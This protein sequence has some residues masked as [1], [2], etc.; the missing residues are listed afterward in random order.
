[1]LDAAERKRRSTA[2]QQQINRSRIAAERCFVCDRERG[3]TGTRTMC[4]VCADRMHALA[5]R[6]IAERSAHGL[7]IQCGRNNHSRTQHC[8]KCRDRR[9]ARERERAGLPSLAP[10]S[11]APHEQRVITHKLSE[12]QREYLRIKRRE[13]RARRRTQSEGNAATLNP[14]PES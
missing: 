12:E 9:Y 10:P 4:R 6:R 2:R 8:L 14:S 7:C 11:L 1:M 13:S 3:A 5:K